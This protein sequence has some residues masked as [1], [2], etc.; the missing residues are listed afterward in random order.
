VLEHGWIS[1]QG[2][3]ITGVGEASP[4]SE[5][6]IVELDG[7][8]VLP[9][10]IDLHVHG[11]GGGDFATGGVEGARQAVAFHR[12]HGT[13]R[14]LASLL[15]AESA[16]TTAA[17][18]VLAPMVAS[19]ALA[20]VHLEGPF[21]SPSYC[22]AH[23]PRLLRTPDPQQLEEL[24]RAA[25]GGPAVVTLAPELPGALAAVRRVAESGAV[26]AIGHS[27]ATYEQAVRAIDAGARLATHL[28]NA[29]RPFR[30]REPGIVG[31]A[32]DHPEVVCELINDGAHVHDA[33]LRL[34]F[35]LGPGR[36]ALVSD[37]IAAA[38]AGDGR[39]RLGDQTVE[40]RA[41]VATLEGTAVLAG[42]TLTMDRAV[43][44]AVL[45]VGLMP[46]LVA[47]AA[48]TTP[49]RVLGLEDVTGSLVPGLAADLVVLDAAWHVRGVMVAGQWVE[50]SP[51]PQKQPIDGPL[52]D[53]VEK[54][55]K[56]RRNH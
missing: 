9:G 23:N 28:F 19:G 44:R 43:R 6:P 30:H 32:M 51:P 54:T 45:E 46:H 31:A 20:G 3:A 4:G 13:T 50:G 26:A 53:T 17:L 47:A 21:L 14:M 48:A 16:D 1:I 37:A 10:F 41:G 25:R 8:W 22:G 7:A 2:S 34:A 39:Y 24:L 38:G 35:G 12:A 52:C 11:G 15:S 36:V 40:V 18:G 49:A 29:M 55:A 5:G 42:S 33:A 56:S 27:D